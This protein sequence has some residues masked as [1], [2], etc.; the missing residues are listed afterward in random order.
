MGMRGWEGCEIV[1]FSINL[2]G[3]SLQGE[4][5]FLQLDECFVGTDQVTNE[6]AGMLNLTRGNFVRRFPETVFSHKSGQRDGQI[7]VSSSAIWC[8]DTNSSLSLL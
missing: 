4:V 2:E 8:Q 7:E 1:P 6:V 5:L 3:C